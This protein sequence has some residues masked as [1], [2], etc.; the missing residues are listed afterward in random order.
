MSSPDLKIKSEDSL[1][2]LIY[3]HGP[4]YYFLFDYVEVQYLSKKNIEL[5]IDLID[6]YDVS[7][8]RKLWA[9]ICRRLVLD[10]TAK[11]ENPRSI[12][13]Q[14]KN[15]V[16]ENGIFEF[17]RKSSNGNIYDSK[18]IDV[19]STKIYDGEEQ[20]LFDKS[21]E[22]RFRLENISNRYILF[23]FKDKKINFAKY[24][25]SV[26]SVSWSSGWPRSWK[27]EGSNDKSSWE[28]IDEKNDDES[29]NGWGKSNTFSCSENN[30]N[31]YRFIRF[32][33][34]ISHIG[35]NKFLLSEIEFYGSFINIV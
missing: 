26:P 27:I 6:N 10:Q 9:S 25:L 17:L 1:F 14:I 3:S 28:L 12:E 5:L 32:K 31:F 22:T 7:L 24:Y 16:C 33:D 18:L 19:E 35:N 13:K 29:L 8:H 15:I 4:N 11:K 20:S 2:E 23:D 34:L 30:N 21:Q